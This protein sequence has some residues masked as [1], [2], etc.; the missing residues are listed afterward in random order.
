MKY[1]RMSSEEVVFNRSYANIILLNRSIPSYKFDKDEEGKVKVVFDKLSIEELISLF[2][3]Y[4]RVYD[5]DGVI[6][7]DNGDGTIFVK[8]GDNFERSITY[9]FF[10]RVF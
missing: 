7:K 6:V 1:F 3:R 5:N 4:I 9:D 10:Q 2:N 8:D